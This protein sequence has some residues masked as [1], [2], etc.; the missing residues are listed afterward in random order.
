MEL[1]PDS[2]MVVKCM[3]VFLWVRNT[4][5]EQV[6]SWATCSMLLALQDL[7]SHF[8]EAVLNMQQCCVD[9]SLLSESRD[10]QPAV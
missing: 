10:S 7:L 9:K 6:Q 3:S 5:F 8:Q 4:S 2:L 1:A